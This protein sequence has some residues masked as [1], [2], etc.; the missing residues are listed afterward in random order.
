ME[1]K[2]LLELLTTAIK[3]IDSG[4]PTCVNSFVEE[5]NELLQEADIIFRFQV[6]DSDRRISVSVI[7][8]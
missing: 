6:T 3:N 1:E 5:A 2:S 4:C 8:T 7:A